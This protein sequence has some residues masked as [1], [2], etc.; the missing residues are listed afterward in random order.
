M[1]SATTQSSV[2]L[3]YASRATGVVALVLLTGAV[4][5][6]IMVRRR[7]AL[8]GLPRSGA[9]SLHR[10]VTLLAVTFV[11][12]HVVTAIADPFVTIGVAAAVVPFVSGYQPFWLGLGAV[13]ADLM[14]AL[15]VTSLLRAHL[16]RRT[17]RAVHWLAYLSWP[18]ALA[19]SIGSSEDLRS[20]WLLWL[21]CG[22]GVAVAAALAWRV[23][24]E[25]REPGP[26]GRPGAVLAAQ[27][28]ALREPGRLPDGAP[29]RLTDGGPGPTPMPGRAPLRAGAR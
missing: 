11:A 15:V 3:W 20:G 10:S 2:T 24:T 7:A 19:H 6:G 26:A 9:S 17:W 21:A 4:L 25:L 28:R 8:P 22:C 18:T 23:T 12:V 29:G 27:E 5:L 1:T 16:G 13:S 14:A